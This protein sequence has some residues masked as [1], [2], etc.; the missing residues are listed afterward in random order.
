MKIVFSVLGL[1]VVLGAL[2]GLAY[3]GI[4]PVQKMAGKNPAMAKLLRLAHLAS[5]KPKSVA[6]AVVQTK[7]DP[8]MQAL[9]AQQQQLAANRAQ[10][11]KDKA[12]FEA[13]KQQAANPTAGP[14]AINGAGNSDAAAKLSAIY[15]TM[16]PDD[17]AKI[18]AKLP[19]PVVIQNL[20]SLDEEQAGKV[21]A[22]LPSDRAARLT[23]LMMAKASVA[24]AVPQPQMN[25]P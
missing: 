13:E 21:L 14:S 10:F 18:F 9:Q 23:Q 25:L 6:K 7:P 5:A 3:F 8:A 11:D 2:Y 22:A 19:D 15:A 17:I 1:A 12:A 16:Q 24:S 4:I 20:M